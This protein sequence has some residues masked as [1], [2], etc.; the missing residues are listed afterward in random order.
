MAPE[1][2]HRVAGA[3][4]VAP[5]EEGQ[6]R[7]GGTAGTMR[8]V[9]AYVLVLAANR[10]EQAWPPHVLRNGILVILRYGSHAFNG[11]I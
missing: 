7:G 8:V 2:R 3:G 11:R 5:L 9:V 6:S 1:G 4:E 10:A